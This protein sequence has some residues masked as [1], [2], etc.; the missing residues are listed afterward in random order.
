M[1]IIDFI[2]KSA[3]VCYEFITII[4]INDKFRA[5]FLFYVKIES[6]GRSMYF[7]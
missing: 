2:G 6:F 7:Q 3:I 4:A 1:I 5:F